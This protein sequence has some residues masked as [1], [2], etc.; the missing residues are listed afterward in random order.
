MG[1]CKCAGGHCCAPPAVVDDFGVCGGNSSSGLLQL[2]LTAAVSSA[3][4]HALGTLLAQLVAALGSLLDMNSAAISFS[5]QFAPVAGNVPETWLLSC[6][7]G[8]MNVAL[9]QGFRQ[10]A[11]AVLGLPA[12]QA[13][14]TSGPSAIGPPAAAQVGTSLAKHIHCSAC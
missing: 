7:G 3:S 8:R 4:Q 14:L 13:T 12:A 5:Q 6:A 1:S 9:N 11:A 10:R 2:T